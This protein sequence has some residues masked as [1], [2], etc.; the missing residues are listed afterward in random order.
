V[1]NRE[2]A[3]RFLEALEAGEDARAL[4]DA[5]AEAAIAAGEALIRRAEKV[6]GGGRHAWRHAI[7]LAEELARNDA[8]NEGMREGFPE[9]FGA[10]RTV[11]DED[12][13]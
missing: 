9:G 7:E 8:P 6:Q 12:S 2:L 4:R 11:D 10:E 3:A 1:D 13:K 5:L